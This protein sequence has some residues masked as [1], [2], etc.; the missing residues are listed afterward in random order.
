M[1]L[2]ASCPGSSP[3]PLPPA[4]RRIH[5]TG[6][7]LKGSIR[8]PS[9]VSLDFFQL[10]A[11]KLIHQARRLARYQ[12][13][14]TTFPLVC[15]HCVPAGKSRVGMRPD[16]LYALRQVIDHRLQ[17]FGNLLTVRPITLAQSTAS[18]VPCLGHE[19]QYR[20]ITPIAL[21]LWVLTY[22]PA[23]L[24]RVQSKHRRIRVQ[25][26]FRQLHV[27]RVPHPLTQTRRQRQMQRQRES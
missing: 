15:L 17:I 2:A 27:R 11:L 13:K 23:N 9:S 6:K 22:P 19:G 5:E 20:L 25:R 12:H 14:L 24:R 7:R 3:S 1:I 10:A 4:K 21:V 8:L 18:Q 26:L 16:L